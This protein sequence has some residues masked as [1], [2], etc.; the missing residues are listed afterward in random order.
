MRTNPDSFQG[1]REEGMEMLLKIK[2]ELNMKIVTEFTTIEQIKKYGKQVDMI[3]IGSRNMF[4]Y[5]LLKA[6]GKTKNMILLKRGFCASYEEWLLAAE[7]IKREGNDKIILC[8][9][10]IRSSFSKETRNVLDIQAI[11]YIKHNTN[12][13]IIVDPSHASGHAYMVESMSKAALVAGADGLIIEVHYNP[14][15]SKSDSNQTIDFKTLDNIIEF[16]QKK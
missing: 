3:Q 14:Q 8:E 12:Y 15:E 11:P 10:G 4:N 16:N 2:K 13:K 7:Y 5:E 1:L 6:A 9:R